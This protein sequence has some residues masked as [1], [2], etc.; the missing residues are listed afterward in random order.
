MK[1]KTVILIAL[2]WAH[3]PYGHAAVVLTKDINMNQC[4]HKYG[5]VFKLVAWA[6]DTHLPSGWVHDQGFVYKLCC[7]NCGAVVTK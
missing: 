5:A 2:L 1:Y 7:P 3:V 4:E 6:T